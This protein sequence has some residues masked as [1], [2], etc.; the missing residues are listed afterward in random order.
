M[1][2]G[3]NSKR[4]KL[5]VIIIRKFQKGKDGREKKS[6][7]FYHEKTEVLTGHLVRNVLQITR[8]KLNKRAQKDRCESHLQTAEYSCKRD[9]VRR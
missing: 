1:E 4:N 3:S 6:L 7:S 2:R 9:S 8:Y 5:P